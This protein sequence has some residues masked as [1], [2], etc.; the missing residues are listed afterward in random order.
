[1]SFFSPLHFGVVF[2][3]SEVFLLNLLHFGVASFFIEGLSF[4]PTGEGCDNAPSVVP[5][6][7]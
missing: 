1:M 7:Y 3:L 6:A 5:L 2:L 4:E